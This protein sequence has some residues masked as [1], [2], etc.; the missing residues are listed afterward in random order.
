MK[1]A[2]TLFI[3]LLFTICNTEANNIE[4]ITQS[5]SITVKFE[6]SSVQLEL[7]GTQNVSILFSRPL[8]QSTDIIFTYASSDKLI[9]FTQSL[10]IVRPLPN[11]TVENGTISSHITLDAVNAG[12]VTIG[13]N[14]SSSEFGDISRTFVK[15]TVVHSSAVTIINI[16]IGWM[17]FVAWSIS[18]Y[19]QI[20]ENFR[21]KSVEGLNFDF[22]AYNIT[23]HFSYGVFNVC[24]FWAASVQTEYFKDHPRGV[25]P[26]QPNDVFFSIHATLMCII[27][28]IQCFVLES[29][30][31]RVSIICRVLLSIMWLFLLIS[32]FIAVGHAI[33]WLMF[34][35]FFSYVKLAITVIKYIPQAWMNFRR[36]ST[37]GWSIGN[38]LLDF[39]G[40]MLSL[41]QMFLIA[42]NTDDW[43]SIMGDPTKF[44]L[45][46]FSV[47][48]DV[49]FLIQHYILY[50]HAQ[51]GY[52]VINVDKA[53]T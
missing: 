29:G 50:R 39:T 43:S 1:M 52:I 31:Q 26:V 5:D 49:L 48:F 35:Y 38:V 32:L 10:E 3:C 28:V 18:F 36:K 25:I 12:S 51:H 15:V 19:P 23:G 21:R 13:I 6:P 40:G 24:L 44:G 41:L 34:L 22:V 42:Y 53:E 17:Y 9:T 33:T 7:H 4:S 27:T 14:E 2:L 20:I 46:L 11:I 8:T 47:L 45:G 30:G 16:V 37:V